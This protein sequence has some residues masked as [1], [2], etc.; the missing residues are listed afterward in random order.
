M[1]NRTGGDVQVLEDGFKD[2]STGIYRYGIF[3]FIII[4]QQ[5]RIFTISFLDASG[6]C[7]FQ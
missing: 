1:F 3:S 7:S 2:S 5:A 4:P 6:S